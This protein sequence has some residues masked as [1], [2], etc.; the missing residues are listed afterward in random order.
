VPDPVGVRVL[1]GHL[2][3]SGCCC[4]LGAA[5]AGKEI[6]YI[7]GFYI[8]LLCN[9]CYTSITNTIKSLK[10]MQVFVRVNA[11]FCRHLSCRAMER[12]KILDTETK[13]YS[14]YRIY[15]QGG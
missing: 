12:A 6:K 14:K 3:V 11:H 4:S 8:V 9:L 13:K 1:E 10:I 15:P 7:K 2:L 5:D